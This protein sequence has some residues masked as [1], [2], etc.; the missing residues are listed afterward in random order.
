MGVMI[1]DGQT[2]WSPPSARVL[3]LVLCAFV[4]FFSFCFHQVHS[5]NLVCCVVRRQDLWVDFAKSP[6]QSAGVGSP[7]GGRA[8]LDQVPGGRAP[9]STVALR[10]PLS[11]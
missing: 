3:A 2:S 7:K 4:F 11:P 9:G 8:T 10:W 5:T 6:S 1:M